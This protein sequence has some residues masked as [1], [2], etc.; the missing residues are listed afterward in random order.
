M[1]CNEKWHPR[2]R[3]ALHIPSQAHRK[4]DIVML[5]LMMADSQMGALPDVTSRF[6]KAH[7]ISQGGQVPSA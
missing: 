5:D 6:P 3:N 2:W 4:A 1:H 7:G